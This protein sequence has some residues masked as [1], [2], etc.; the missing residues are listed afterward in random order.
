MKLIIVSPQFCDCIWT[1]G[2]V[3]DEAPLLHGLVVSRLSPDEGQ[4][5][6][7]PGVVGAHHHG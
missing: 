5:E 6:R 4:R 2:K 3:R 1:H 7:E